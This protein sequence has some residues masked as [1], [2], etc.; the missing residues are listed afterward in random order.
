MPEPRTIRADEVLEGDY[1][2]GWRVR[3]VAV[4]GHQRVFVLEHPVPSRGEVCELHDITEEIE[5]DG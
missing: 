3:L 1:I 2:R 5:V 4:R